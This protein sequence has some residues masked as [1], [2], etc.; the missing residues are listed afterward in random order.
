[1]KGSASPEIMII[2]IITG[3]ITKITIKKKRF[4]SFEY[5]CDSVV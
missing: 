5:S 4:M 3:D 1:M 2:I